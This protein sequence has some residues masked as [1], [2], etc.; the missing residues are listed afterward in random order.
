M[1]T[2]PPTLR[3]ILSEAEAADYLNVS[4]RTIQRLRTE[5]AIPY[6]QIRRRIRYRRTD[7]DRYLAKQTMPVLRVSRQ[8]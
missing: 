3:D 1:P 2:L 7:L 8:S 5:R 4:V 6:A